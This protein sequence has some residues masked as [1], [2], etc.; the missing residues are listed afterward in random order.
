M[1]IHHSSP[2]SVRWN[3]QVFKTQVLLLNILWPQ[4]WERKWPPHPS[5]FKKNQISNPPSQMDE[6]PLKLTLT[7]PNVK[8]ER[9]PKMIRFAQARG[10]FLGHHN[11]M[12]NKWQNTCHHSENCKAHQNSFHCDL[13]T[14]PS[15]ADVYRSLFLCSD[16]VR[17]QVLST[18]SAGRVNKNRIQYKESQNI[19]VRIVPSIL[20]KNTNNLF[21]ILSTDRPPLSNFSPLIA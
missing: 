3:H 16:M 15:M 14:D 6:V 18:H 4:S 10:K 20:V 11:Q 5:R 21:Q 2:P 1:N 7:R 19:S 8:T 12:H 13:A 17:L 9:K